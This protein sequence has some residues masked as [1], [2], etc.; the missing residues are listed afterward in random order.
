[1]YERQFALWYALLVAIVY[2]AD[3]LQM[4]AAG[5]DLLHRHRIT[6]N[7]EGSDDDQDSDADVDVGR[8]LGP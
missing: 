8:R 5:G 2:T 1:M 6:T 3:S 4:W 7:D